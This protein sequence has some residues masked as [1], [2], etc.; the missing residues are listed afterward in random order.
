MTGNV[1]DSRFDIIVRITLLLDRGNS[2]VRTFTFFLPWACSR[3][4]LCRN[5][6]SRLDFCLR[7]VVIVS[8][9][10]NAV[11]STKHAML[12]PQRRRHPPDPSLELVPSGRLPTWQVV[13]L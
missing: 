4:L 2:T 9:T 8:R 7:S 6:Q 13:V 1:F 12:E 3:L 11:L 10:I 5:V